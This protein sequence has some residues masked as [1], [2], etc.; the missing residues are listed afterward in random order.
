MGKK[1][2]DD[3]WWIALLLTALGGAALYYLHAGRGE[4]NDAALIPNDL[5][6][7]IDLVVAVLNKQFGNSWA[8]HGLD[9]LSYYLEKTLPP[10][11]LALVTVIYQVELLSRQQQMTSYEKQRTAVHWAARRI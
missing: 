1:K 3:G 6:S 8:D 2:S 9:A 4:E 7:N 10:Q 5:E 11:A